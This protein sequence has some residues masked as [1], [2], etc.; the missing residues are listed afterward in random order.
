MHRMGA[1]KLNCLM[2]L[3]VLE[4]F[5]QGGW[6][7]VHAWEPLANGQLLSI[8]GHLVASAGASSNQNDCLSTLDRLCQLLNDSRMVG[9]LRLY[10]IADDGVDVERIC[11]NS[12]APGALAQ[13]AIVLKRSECSQTNALA[14]LLALWHKAGELLANKQLAAPMTTGPLERDYSNVRE[15]A[16]E[17][18]KKL[19]WPLESLQCWTDLLF[20]VQKRHSGLHIRIPIIGITPSQEG[21]L[22][23]LL[24]VKLEG[25]EGELIE[26]PELALLPLR[27]DLLICIAE[28]HHRYGASA[29]IMWGIRIRSADGNAEKRSPWTALGDKTIGAAAAV[30]FHLLANNAHYDESCAIIAGAGR[31]AADPF[32]DQLAPVAGLRPCLRAIP[33][34]NREHPEA[35]IRSIGV[36]AANAVPSRISRIAGI[37]TAHLWSVGEALDFCRQSTANPTSQHKDWLHRFRNWF[38]SIARPIIIL[39]YFLLIVWF[40]LGLVRLA[41][42][43]QVPNSGQVLLWPFCGFIVTLMSLFFRSVQPRLIGLN[44]IPL[45][46]PIVLG[47]SI[48]LAMLSLI[49][50]VSLS[51]PGRRD[52]LVLLASALNGLLLFLAYRPL[53]ERKSVQSPTSRACGPRRTITLGR[54]FVPGL[55]ILIAANALNCPLI[56][57]LATLLPWK[58]GHLRL[59]LLPLWG[60]WMIVNID[61]LHQAHRR[62]AS[63]R[64]GMIATL[65]LA[66]YGLTLVWVFMLLRSLSPVGLYLGVMLL[67]ALLPLRFTKETL[68]ARVTR[69]AEPAIWSVIDGIAQAAGQ[70]PPD[71][72][73]TVAEVNAYAG[74]VRGRNALTL[75]LPMM[76]ILRTSEL[77]AVIAHEFGHYRADDTTWAVR[78]YRCRR[79]ID[80]VLERFRTLEEMLPRRCQ[81]A[82]LR[83][84]VRLMSF[85]FVVYK[86]LFHRALKDVV[87]AQEYSADLFAGAVAGPASLCNALRAVERASKAFDGYWRETVLPIIKVGYRPHLSEGFLSYLPNDKGIGYTE[88][89]RVTTSVGFAALDFHPSIESRLSNLDIESDSNYTEWKTDAPAIELSNT[90]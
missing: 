9:Q 6:Q 90:R 55:W 19:D 69:E 72:L 89:K 56:P 44:R 46:L 88:R 66:F 68:G 80:N 2:A 83:P 59:Q 81:L 84:S 5:I 51:H 24:L 30:G 49:G 76:A 12:C 82:L 45:Y 26:D 77:R 21:V 63:A 38:Q 20:G 64:I 60:V 85:P 34:W 25:A 36:A 62:Y 1:A 14:E 79:A 75:G 73:Y 17:V 10:Y 86:A 32:E 57:I 7:D 11:R 4:R 52:P 71:V 39:F 18:A 78:I 47:V 74:R 40:L 15:T 42:P 65:L 70:R 58:H 27:S 35:A 16:V 3:E 48:W 41:L 22:G 29:N 13:A 53:R 23:D 43:G 8:L 87:Q 33:V 31:K 37:K 67:L 28:Q 54:Y 61:A 50:F